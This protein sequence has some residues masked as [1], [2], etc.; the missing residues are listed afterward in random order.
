MNAMSPE[1]KAQLLQ[2][3]RLIE[4]CL[5]PENLTC[6]GELPRSEV[7]KRATRLHT[8]RRAIIIEL[9]YEPTFAELYP[10]FANAS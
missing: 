5:S 10:Q 8:K 3:F 9:G 6:D 2:D 1:R 4:A 7:R